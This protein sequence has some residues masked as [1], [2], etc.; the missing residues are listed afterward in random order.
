[1]L[2]T[3]QRSVNLYNT[4]MY[5]SERI[6]LLYTEHILFSHPDFGQ[7]NEGVSSSYGKDRA[8]SPEICLCQRLQLLTVYSAPKNSTTAMDKS[9]TT[10]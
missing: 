3:I 2:H 7:C 1:M 9:Y 5:N 4:Y 6:C 10:Y 8:A